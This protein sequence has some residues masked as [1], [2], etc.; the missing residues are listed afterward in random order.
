[1]IGITHRRIINTAVNEGKP[2]K[3]AVFTSTLPF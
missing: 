1:M 3:N 2:N